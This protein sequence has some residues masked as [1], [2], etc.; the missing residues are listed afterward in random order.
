MPCGSRHKRICGKCRE[1]SKVA[2]KTKSDNDLDP[3]SSQE[4]WET[5]KSCICLVGQAHRQVGGL[6][7]GFIGQAS[8]RTPKLFMWTNGRTEW[9]G[10]DGGTKLS[11]MVRAVSLFSGERAGAFLYTISI[12]WF[13]DKMIFPQ[14]SHLVHAPLS[15]GAKVCYLLCEFLLVTVHTTTNASTLPTKGE[16]TYWT[17]DSHLRHTHH[18]NG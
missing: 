18:L 16:C 9:P 1:N 5:V 6:N 8:R 13:P 4:V 15:Q 3:S 7:T 10:T 12:F 14:K 2:I 11:P 17:S